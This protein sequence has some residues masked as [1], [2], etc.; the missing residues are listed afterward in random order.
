MEFSTILLGIQIT[1]IGKLFD[2]PIKI[3]YCKKYIKMDVVVVFWKRKNNVSFQ[4]ILFLCIQS[5][6]FF[7]SSPIKSSFPRAVWFPSFFCFFACFFFFLSLLLCHFFPFVFCFAFSF[8]F[9]FSFAITS[10]QSFFNSWIFNSL[11]IS[12]W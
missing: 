1:F 2:K 8:Y 6:F 12:F 3:S 4:I 10:F 9:F 5:M 11:I 7:Y